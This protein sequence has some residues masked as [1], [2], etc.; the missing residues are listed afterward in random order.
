M[1][2]AGEAA[3]RWRMMQESGSRTYETFWRQAARW[4]AGP[5]PDPVSVSIPEG[6]EPEDEVAIGIETRDAEF[7]PVADALVDVTMTE[8]GGTPRTLTVRRDPAAPG[9]F[10]ATLPSST[11][12]L[13]RVRVDARRG[14]SSIG[15]AERWFLVGGSDREFAD[16]RLNEGFLRRLA[17]NSG[18]RYV[19]VDEAASIVPPLRDVVPH[20]AVPER[21]DLWNEPWAFA[22]V[23]LL[24][25]AEWV[26]RRRWGLQ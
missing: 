20:D 5:A 2:F 4:L 12:G 10:A 18:G 24:L 14:T 19:T 3:W 26:L 1:V 23:V 17:R 11:P 21:R 8:P 22:L 16:P 15:S 7:A 13:Y 25:S 6:I 9:R